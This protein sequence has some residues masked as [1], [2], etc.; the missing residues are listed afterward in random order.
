MNLGQICISSPENI[1]KQ[2]SLPTLNV[3][4]FQASQMSFLINSTVCARSK[5]SWESSFYCQQFAGR[6][7]TK[8][9]TVLTFERV[10]LFPSPS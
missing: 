4:P 6:S 10:T 9:N 7:D 1:P 3:F 8:N 2:M 5:V